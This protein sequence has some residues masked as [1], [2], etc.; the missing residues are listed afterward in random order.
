MQSISRALRRGNA[1]IIKGIGGSFYVK[2]LKR[3]RSLTPYEIKNI[4][5][6]DDTILSKVGIPYVKI[7]SLN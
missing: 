4:I 3:R 6:N 2:R 7:E 5:N 1:V